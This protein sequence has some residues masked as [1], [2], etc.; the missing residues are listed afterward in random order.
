MASAL[1]LSLQ[2]EPAT[3]VKSPVWNGFAQGI[4]LAR[5]TPTGTVAVGVG[6]VVGANVL[7]ICGLI[8][9]GVGV[10]NVAA[11]NTW[12]QLQRVTGALVDD[13]TGVPLFFVTVIALTIIIAVRIQTGA[14]RDAVIKPL[15]T[16]INVFARLTVATQPRR[17]SPA[18][19]AFPRRSNVGAGHPGVTGGGSAAVGVFAHF[20]VATQPRRTSPA[21]VA[22]PRRSNVG[23]G[24]PGVTGGGSAAVG[25][26]TAPSPLS[27]TD[28]PRTC[29]LRPAQQ[30]RCRSLR[31]NRGRK[32]NRRCLRILIIATSP[33]G[34][35]PH[36]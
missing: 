19:V 7:A 12:F 17:T 26:F 8:G 25:V 27:P 36:V 28:K 13:H 30:R 2:L 15:S 6:R 20:T 4:A 14:V 21:R 29:S 16:L 24:H 5:N 1:Q 23:A 11:A 18:R 34:Q 32:R 9:V 10:G 22:F 31:R 3:V 35:A 33:D